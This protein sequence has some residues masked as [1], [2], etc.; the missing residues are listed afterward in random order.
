[1]TKL[2]Q[3]P[4]R[5]S[6]WRCFA[7]ALRGG[8]VLI[9]SQTNAQLHVLATLT[10]AA[11]GL[12]LHISRSDWCWIITAIAL[13]WMAEALNTAIEFLGDEI[14][15]EHRPLIGRAKDLG[16]ASVL[17]AAGAAFLI[18][19]LVFIPHVHAAFN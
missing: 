4:R 15:R 13:V 1:M 2:Q 8:Y 10:V 19:L 11:L 18:G 3:P 7:H 9:R 12:G 14:S 17:V 16:A 5:R 6:Y